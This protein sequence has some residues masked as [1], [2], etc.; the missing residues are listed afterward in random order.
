MN[1]TA[2]RMK[3]YN[4]LPAVGKSQPHPLRIRKGKNEIYFTIS[5]KVIRAFYEANK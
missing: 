5:G 1:S 3:Q 4:A 2:V